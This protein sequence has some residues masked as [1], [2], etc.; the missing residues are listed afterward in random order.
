[1]EKTAYILNYQNTGVSVILAA[2]ESELKEKLK[3]AI[4]EEMGADE[5]GQFS[6][7]IGR[8]GDWGERTQVKA[9]Y[10]Q[11]GLLIE[12]YEFSLTKTVVY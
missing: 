10:V 7:E 8:I 4:I 1:M 11:D 5:D 12:D 6:S 9:T 3:T 2:D